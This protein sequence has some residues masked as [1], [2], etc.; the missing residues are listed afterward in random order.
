MTCNTVVIVSDYAELR[1]A[2]ALSISRAGFDVATEISPEA[3]LQ[4][5]LPAAVSCVV[6]DVA[7]GGLVAAHQVA[8][9][10]ALCSSRPVLVLAEAGDVPTAVQ[11]M[12]QGA[13]DVIQKPVDDSVVL[14]R[15]RR[16]KAADPLATA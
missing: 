16:L 9:L 2:L 11:A 1:E 6:L 8:R 3:F 12:R 7:E 10:S 14:Q 5:V 15:I 4:A 13:I